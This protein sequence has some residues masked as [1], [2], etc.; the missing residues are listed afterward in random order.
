MIIGLTKDNKVCDLRDAEKIKTIS[1]LKDNFT[2]EQLKSLYQTEADILEG[3]IN[4][5][6]EN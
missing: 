6:N 3:F 4:Y 5:L 1:E 2:S